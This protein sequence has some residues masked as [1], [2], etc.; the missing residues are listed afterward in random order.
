[1]KVIDSKESGIIII[2][3]E[4]VFATR[5]TARSQKGSIKRIVK[6]SDKDKINTKMVN[7]ILANSKMKRKMVSGPIHSKMETITKVNGKM[8]CNMVKEST[9]TKITIHGMKVIGGMTRR[10]VK[11]C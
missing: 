6:D 3:A 7:P 11:E 8:T 9:T 1:V 5:L 2:Q 4:L 10:M